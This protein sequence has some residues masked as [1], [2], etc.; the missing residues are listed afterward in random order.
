[1]C[2]AAVVKLLA[3]QAPVQPKLIN[4]C[5]SVIGPNYGISV[6]GVY[7]P[8]NGVLTDVQGSGG[9][10]P[11]DAPRSARIQEALFAEGWFNTVTAE[12]FG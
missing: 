6:A 1:V 4:T 8:V 12:V 5:Y 9:V 10:S 3:G 2:A 11:A 7:E